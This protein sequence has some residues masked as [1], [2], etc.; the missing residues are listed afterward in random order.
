MAP[1]LISILFNKGKNPV[2]HYRLS[3]AVQIVNTMSLK[4][5][6]SQVRLHIPMAELKCLW[7]VF[8]NHSSKLAM[9]FHFLLSIST[10]RCIRLLLGF[11]FSSL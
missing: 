5:N 7:I 10:L 9:R 4:L 2:L 6:V 3:F 1:N 8:L 11:S